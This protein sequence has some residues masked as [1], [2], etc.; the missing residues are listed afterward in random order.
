MK[1]NIFIDEQPHSIHDDMTVGALRNEI[2]PGA[3]VIIINGFPAIEEYRLQEGDHV[4]LIKRGEIPAREEL[5][6]QMIARHSPGVH[7]RMKKAVVGIA[8]LGGLGSS[9]SIALARMGVG[10]LIIADHDIVVP[11]NLNRQQYFI[12]QIGLQKTDA[13]KKILA[14]V[15]PY[16]QVVAHDVMLTK[17]NIPTIFQRADIVVECFDKAE[18]KT[19][20]LEAVAE[21][22]PEVCMVAASGLA[23]FG[24]S[25]SIQTWRIGENIFVV[26]D[27][28]RAAG[29]GEGLMAPRVGIAA[30]HQANLVVSLL[31]DP[32]QTIAQIPDLTE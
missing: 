5:E 24:D 30:H 29:P 25:N 14:L 21:F 17:K 6:A 15:N 3:D 31:I 27:M 8:G 11:S 1:I 23:G 12:D 19:M 4:V 18:E 2:K 16:V 20:I 13:M 7:E 26:G 10:T 28:V 9:V 22:L 32:V